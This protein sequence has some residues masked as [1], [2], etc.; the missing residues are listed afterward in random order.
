MLRILVVF[1]WGA[2]LKQLRRSNEQTDQNG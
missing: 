1:S 2:G